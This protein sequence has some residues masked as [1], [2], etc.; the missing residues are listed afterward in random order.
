MYYFK[1]VFVSHFPLSGLLA[2]DRKERFPAIC[3][4]VTAC[5]SP[6]NGAQ[7][8]IRHM[9]AFI[10]S[11]FSALTHTRSLAQLCPTLCIVVVNVEL[12]NRM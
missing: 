2:L 5:H 9:G 8:F 3:I 11:E 6:N 7:A 12:L 4:I 10:H 1:S